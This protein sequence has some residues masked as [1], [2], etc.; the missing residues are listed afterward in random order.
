VEVTFDKLY[1]EI[2]SP[3]H[4]AKIRLGF[5]CKDKYRRPFEEEVQFNKNIPFAYHGKRAMK[6]GSLFPTYEKFLEESNK[7]RAHDQEEEAAR[8]GG[9][10]H[11]KRAVKKFNVDVALHQ[12]LHKDPKG[13]S[14]GSPFMLFELDDEIRRINNDEYISKHKVERIG[15]GIVKD[16]NDLEF[17]ANMDR[18][19]RMKTIRNKLTVIYNEKV[20][21]IH[22]LHRQV[23]HR[24]ETDQQLIDEVV[25]SEVLLRHLNDRNVAMERDMV[26]AERIRDGY[27]ELLKVLK[28]N[29]PYI[30]SHVKALEIE[31]QLAEKQFQELCEHRNKLYHETEMAN[32]FKREQLLERIEYFQHARYEV[33]LKKKQILRQ[34]R[35]MKGPNKRD[36]KNINRRMTKSGKVIP[37]GRNR[38]DSMNESD[39]S[40]SDSEG[41]QPEKKEIQLTAPVMHFLNALVRKTTFNEAVVKETDT[42]LEDIKRRFDE[43]D[44]AGSRALSAKH[45]RLNRMGTMDSMNVSAFEEF[46]AEAAATANN[47]TTGATPAQAVTAQSAASGAVGGGASDDN[48]SVHGGSQSSRNGNVSVAGSLMSR[49]STSRHRRSSGFTSGEAF[50]DRRSSGFGGALPSL[51]PDLL[52]PPYFMSG[53]HSNMPSHPSSPHQGMV[54]PK[55]VVG[56]QLTQLREAVRAFIPHEVTIADHRTHSHGHHHHHK[57]GPKNPFQRAYELLLEKTSS[58]SH[59]ELIERFVEGR[60]LLNSLRKQQTL[61]DS[62]I[63]QLQSEHAEL[64]TAFNDLAFISDETKVDGATV[65]ADG[66]PAATAALPSISEDTVADQF[67]SSDRYLDNQLFAKEVRMNQVMRN[68]DRAEQ[69]VSDVRTAVGCLIHLMTINA[70]LLHALPKS[71]PPAIKSSDDIMLGISWFEDRIMALSEAL[72]MDANKPT[73]ANTAD[74][75]K[76]L[77]ERQLDLALL[78]QKMNINQSKP[79]SRSSSRVRAFPCSYLLCVTVPHPA[80]VAVHRALHSKER[81]G[82]ASARASFTRTERRRRSCPPLM[83]SWYVAPS[84]YCA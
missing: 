75:N 54:R 39:S 1:D 68:K 30:E 6:A 45:R 2:T 12:Q 76:P 55:K 56:D 21:T 34:T 67:A 18:V 49:E 66:A 38:S 37:G 36:L 28:N 10:R 29:P 9:V 80:V 24:H 79:G 16:E 19:A 69:I 84:C 26:E 65:G 5:K 64:F 4:I 27:N 25:N 46:A 48:S 53:L 40:G 71:E 63:S 14:G 35:M 31:V 61:V 74:D 33:A 8:N 22:E 42:T 50:A 60:A 20:R 77:H 73:G 7:K 82:E 3:S 57:D 70:K 11:K 47:T 83:P 58:S 13:A 72:A 51:S 23:V 62:R 52:T 17:E 15:G 41:S 32:Q 59:E 44:Q 81:R 78:V 43:E